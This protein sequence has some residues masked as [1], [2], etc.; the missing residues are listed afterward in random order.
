MNHELSQI[1][2]D[3][4]Y[5]NGK[6]NKLTGLIERLKGEQSRIEMRLQTLPQ[7]IAEAEAALLE[8]RTKLGKVQRKAGSKYPTLAIEDI[9]CTVPTPK[10]GEWRWGDLKREIIAVLKSTNGHP[11]STRLLIEH[12]E[13]RFGLSSATPEE[14]AFLRNAVRKPLQKLSKDGVIE[15]IQNPNPTALAYWRWIG[16]D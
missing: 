7:E 9:R 16:L 11:V 6:L 13:I 1:I 12:C 3:I 4:S 8:I 5:E 10:R 15:R 14:K 2:R